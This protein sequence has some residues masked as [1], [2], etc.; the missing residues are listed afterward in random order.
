VGLAGN[1]W[2]DPLASNPLRFV[3]HSCTAN[4]GYFESGNVVALQRIRKGVELTLD[5]SISESDPLWE[6]APQTA[7]G[8]CACGSLRCRGRILSIQSLPHS[9]FRSY[10]PAIPIAFRMTYRRLRTRTRSAAATAGGQDGRV[11]A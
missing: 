9:V 4:V 6:F 1:R 3:N 5:Y 10:L 11:P 8:G 7:G 2:I